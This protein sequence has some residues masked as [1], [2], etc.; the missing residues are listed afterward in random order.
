MI[1]YVVGAIISA[2]AFAALV[3]SLLS[4]R[5]L[6]ARW[7]PT[8]PNAKCIHIDSFWRWGSLANIVTDIVMFALPLPTIW[9]LQISK[10]QKFSLSLIFLTG[11]A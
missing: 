1:C 11:S 9:H 8:I 4:C 6:A 2:N 10:N 5:P 3:T 7:D